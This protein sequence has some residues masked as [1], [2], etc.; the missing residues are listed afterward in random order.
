MGFIHFLSIVF[1]IF[2]SSIR[3]D[4]EDSNNGTTLENAK[5]FCRSFQYDETGINVEEAE[6]FCESLQN[7]GSGVYAKA[8]PI[9]EDGNPGRNQIPNQPDILLNV[10]NLSIEK[11]HLEVENLKLGLELEASV[12]GLVNIQ[13]GVSVNVNNVNL[14][15]TGVKATAMLIVRLDN[16]RDVIHQALHT[17]NNNAQILEKVLKEASEASQNANKL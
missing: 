1:M 2:V 13:G 8:E 14:T 11:I 17:I 16:V 7:E 10:P 15:L 3:C 6:S 5:T 12:A 9:S 4:S